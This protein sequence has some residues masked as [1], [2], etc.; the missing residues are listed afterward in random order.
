MAFAHHLPRFRQAERGHHGARQGQAPS[1]ADAR[2]MGARRRALRALHQDHRFEQEGGA[3]EKSAA[4]HPRAWVGE[5]REVVD[6][7]VANEIDRVG[8]GYSCQS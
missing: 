7:Q 8:S 2:T 1:T 5:V 3:V 6:P 4:V